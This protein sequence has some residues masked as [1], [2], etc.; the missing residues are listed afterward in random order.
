MSNNPMKRP[1]TGRRLRNTQVRQYLTPNDYVMV[2]LRKGMAN[3]RSIV[4]QR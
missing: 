3:W 1:V 4:G 2:P